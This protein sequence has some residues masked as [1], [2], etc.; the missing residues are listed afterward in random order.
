MKWP[1]IIMICLPTKILLNPDL[2]LT[3]LS[4]SLHRKE[5]WK[6]EISV[7]EN[8]MWCM[9]DYKTDELGWSTGG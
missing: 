2:A 1:I 9:K 7:T 8:F 3:R 4:K 5:I 6:S